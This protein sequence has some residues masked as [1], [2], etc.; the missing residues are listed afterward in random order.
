MIITLDP[1]QKIEIRFAHSRDEHGDPQTS[2]GTITVSYD[3]A[4]KRIRVM[5]SDPD[6]TGRVGVIYSENYAAPETRSEPAQ[7]STDDEE[8]LFNRILRITYDHLGVDPLKIHRESDFIDDLGADS[9][10]QVELVMAFEEEFGIDIP[11][12][13]ADAIMTIA[14]AIAYLSKRT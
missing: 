13:D 12:E 7:I 9:L 11:D 4:A 14:D 3:D 10:D 8:M 6:S 2:D 1:N 5:A